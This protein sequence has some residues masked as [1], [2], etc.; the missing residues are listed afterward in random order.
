MSKKVALV[1]CLLVA[2]PA[3]ALARDLTFTVVTGKQIHIGGWYYVN[4]KQNCRELGL[5]K[6]TWI[7]R[8]TG[9][10][11]EITKKAETRQ[12]PGKQANTVFIEYTGGPTGTDTFEFVVEYPRTLDGDWHYKVTVNNFDAGPQPKQ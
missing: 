6:V 1:L 3:A 10:F 2:C 12:C 5:P 11:K 8:P 7:K 4:T 9:T